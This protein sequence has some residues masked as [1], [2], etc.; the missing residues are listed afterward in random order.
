MTQH[1]PAK[2]KV[3]WVPVVLGVLLI[4]SG[5]FALLLPYVSIAVVEVLLAVGL[6][7]LGINRIALGSDPGSAGGVRAMSIVVGILALVL[8]FTI[9][10]APEFGVFALLAFFSVAL[11]FEGFGALSVAFG[12]KLSRGLRALAAVGG[13]AAIAIAFLALVYPAFG[14][15]II[16]FL[17]GIALILS[18]L[19]AI[20]WGLTGVRPTVPKPAIMASE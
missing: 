20:M 2:R 11:L 18:G 8:S 13:V 6:M 12:T 14:V 4:I 19:F 9:I 1:E 3:L 16:Y 5:V 17:F 7:F 15:T 10:V